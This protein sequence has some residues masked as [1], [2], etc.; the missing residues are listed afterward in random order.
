MVKKTERDLFEA[1]HARHWP[2]GDTLIRDG[3][4]YEDFDIQ[5]RFEGWKL[6]R[7]AAKRSA[8]TS[9]ADHG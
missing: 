5:Q 3:K 2:Y 4:G 6:A 8:R 7:L 1:E 9:G